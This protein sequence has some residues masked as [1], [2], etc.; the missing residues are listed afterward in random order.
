MSPKR[1]EQSVKR[2]KI[3]RFN[4]WKRFWNK[5]YGLKVYIV[6]LGEMNQTYQNE[7][8]TYESSWASRKK[9]KAGFWLL[10]SSWRK[11][12]H[13]SLREGKSEPLILCLNCHWTNKVTPKCL[14]PDRNSGH[15]LLK[16]SSGRNSGI[17]TEW[18]STIQ[19]KDGSVAKRLSTESLQCRPKT[20]KLWELW[21]QKRK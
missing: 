14:W 8:V 5:V 3:P 2:A 1:S 13:T 17:P 9:E 6:S 7:D 15:V 19:E 18:I 10:L 12:A 16:S 11:H 4:W 21:L 20:T